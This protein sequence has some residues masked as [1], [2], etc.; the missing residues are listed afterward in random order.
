MCEASSQSSAASWA[1]H[2]RLHAEVCVKTKKKK[3][4]CWKAELPGG[5]N[6]PKWP[7]QKKKRW[8]YM[9]H[10]AAAEAAQL[11]HLIRRQATSLSDAFR[12][13]RH[14][15]N[16]ISIRVVTLTCSEGAAMTHCVYC[17]QTCSQNLH[18]RH[19]PKR[20]HKPNVDLEKY[21]KDLII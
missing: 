11:K 18:Q 5:T 16:T 2:A 20:I 13:K 1:P 9:S 17:S 6:I 8:P 4:H 7:W 21:R 3:H 15:L 19:W 10:D 12:S 14:H